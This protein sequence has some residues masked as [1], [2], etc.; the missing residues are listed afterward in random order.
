[1]ANSKV[2]HIYD[3]TGFKSHY[4]TFIGLWSQGNFNKNITV[5]LEWKL[6]H[7]EFKS[8]SKTYRTMKHIVSLYMKEV[9]EL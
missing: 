8:G 2:K 3:I 5:Y 9:R 1:M 7:L 6:R 4:Q